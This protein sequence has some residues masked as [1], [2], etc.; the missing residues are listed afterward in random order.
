MKLIIKIR[1]TWLFFFMTNMIYQDFLL[2]VIFL[3]AI[4][5][6]LWLYLKSS[7]VNKD[8][9]LESVY[10]EEVST[11]TKTMHQVHVEMQQMIPEEKFEDLDSLDSIQMVKKLKIVKHRLQEF[12]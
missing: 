1:F 5:F 9:S 2:M 3:V 11:V 4:A 12:K 8:V 6:G 10:V 7:K